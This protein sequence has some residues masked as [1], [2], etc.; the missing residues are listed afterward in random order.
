MV[1]I[2]VAI[3]GIITAEPEV[4]ITMVRMNVVIMIIAG[5]AE[6]MAE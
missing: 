6:V 4:I 5:N 2:A 1:V 3:I